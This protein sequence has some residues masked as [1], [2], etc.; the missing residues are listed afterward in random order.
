MVTAAEQGDQTRSRLMD[1]A[2]ALIA[3]RGWG[4]V[5]TRLVA[6]RAGVRS[7][8]VHYHFST[9]NDLLIDAGLRVMRGETQRLADAVTGESGRAGL[10]VLAAA[11]DSYR[12]DDEVSLVIVEVMLAASRHER[13]RTELGALLRTHREGVTHWLRAQGSTDAEAS[14]AVL[15]AALDGLF[16]HRI[17]DDR[18]AALPIGAPL[19]RI[20]GLLESAQGP[21]R[22]E[23]EGDHR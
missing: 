20:T 15:M 3:E 22:E 8:V 14:A 13:L 18:A 7:G 19:Q 16:L 2:A 12:P 5:S 11:V 9:V 1:A 21:E 23:Y 10:E 4:A 6:E 17:V